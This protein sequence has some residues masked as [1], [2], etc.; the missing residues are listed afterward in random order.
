MPKFKKSNATFWVIFKQCAPWKKNI[1][2]VFGNEQSF[3]MTKL[4]GTPCKLSTN[5]TSPVVHRR[6]KVIW[7]NWISLVVSK[8]SD[9]TDCAAKSNSC[10][11]HSLFNIKEEEESFF[12]S[13]A[14]DVC[15]FSRLDLNGSFGVEKDLNA[16]NAAQAIIKRKL[17][18]HK[19]LTK[20]PFC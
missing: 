12:S 16:L 17:F 4:A 8:L 15:S 6:Q 5:R 3:L 18:G 14:L 7:N 2:I 1:L 19:H 20:W 9:S 10:K 13:F 11:L